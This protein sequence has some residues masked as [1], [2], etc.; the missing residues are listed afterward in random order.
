MS[1]MGRPRGARVV[2]RRFVRASVRIFD[3]F[4]AFVSLFLA[5]AGARF[6]FSTCCF[7]METAQCYG[8]FFRH[9]KIQKTGRET[10]NS[11][12]IEIKG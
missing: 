7:G 4:S 2:K 12:I 1:S 3:S 11:E 5:A 10:I 8:M 9:A 6:F